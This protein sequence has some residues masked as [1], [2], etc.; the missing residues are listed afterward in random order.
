MGK[1]IN[2]TL[3]ET[4][5]GDFVELGYNQGDYT[6]ELNVNKRWSKILG[7][8][9]TNDTSNSSSIILKREEVEM[10][11]TYLTNQLDTIEPF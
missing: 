6:Y 4:N 3:V 8:W 5:E 1:L 11:I 7:E 2:E 10:L 9:I